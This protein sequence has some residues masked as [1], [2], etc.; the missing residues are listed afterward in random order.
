MYTKFRHISIENVF[1][2]NWSFIA[3]YT[4]FWKEFYFKQSLSKNNSIKCHFFAI[5]WKKFFYDP[6][7]ITHLTGKCIIYIKNPKNRGSTNTYQLDSRC[8]GHHLFVICFL[9]DTRP[10]SLNYLT[11][12]LFHVPLCIPFMHWRHC[13]C[14][15]PPWVISI[16]Q[17]FRYKNVPNYCKLL[18]YSLCDII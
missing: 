4:F 2:T 9:R 11:W 14:L 7:S 13:E 8:S 18:E 15:C 3:F 17:K 5:H 12:I 6:I 16:N 1:Q 10:R